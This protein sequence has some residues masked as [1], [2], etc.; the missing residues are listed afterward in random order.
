MMNK[1]NKMARVC[2][3]GASN[4]RRV[5]MALV[6]AIDECIADGCSPR[7]DAAVFMIAHQLTWLLTG[8]DFTV[9]NDRMS[10][11]WNRDTKIVELAAITEEA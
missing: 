2:Q 3:E 5:A 4:E 7:N 9:G 8:H 1:R 10:D 11:R 6:E